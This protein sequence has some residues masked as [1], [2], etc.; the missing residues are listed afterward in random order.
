MFFFT[1]NK[2]EPK[3][4]GAANGS[5][6]NGE[7]VQSNGH[8]E[9]V[10]NGDSSA[11]CQPGTSSGTNGK[12]DIAEEEADDDK[13]IAN[14]EVAWEVLELAVQIFTRQGETAY[15]HLAE[16][17]SEL[18]GISFENNHVDVAIK[19]YSKFSIFSKMMGY[20]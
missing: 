5:A 19:D 1:E 17:Y 13:P 4:E 15:A 8:S 16:A 2:G 20:F 10:L 18:A 12:E 7:K 3:P 11:D 14:L 6:T 9:S